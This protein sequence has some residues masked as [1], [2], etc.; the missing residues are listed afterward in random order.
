[1][2]VAIWGA[3]ECGKKVLD[4]LKRQKETEIVAVADKAAAKQEKDWEGYKVCAPEC[5]IEMVENKEIDS[6]VFAF[7][8][9]YFKE[10]TALFKDCVDVNAYIVPSHVQRFMDRFESMEDC[11]VKIDLSKPRLRQFDV[12]LVDH[13]NMKCKGCLRFS[14]LVTEPFF[15]DFDRMIRDWE[16]IKELFWGVERIKL[17]GG[18]PLLSPDIIRYVEEARRIFPDA[19]IMIT[20]NAIL[21]NERQT[22]LFDAMKKNNCFFDISLYAAMEKKEQTIRDIL[23]QY[24]VWYQINYTKG[25]FYKVMSAEGKYDM[26][27][28]YAD[29]TAKNCHHLREGKLS[30]CSRP[31]YVHIMND[32]YG[33]RIPTWDGVWDIYDLHMDAWELDEKLSS[34][35]EACKYCAP[36]ESYQ[37]AR[38]DCINAEMSDWF[39]G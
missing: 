17:M 34:P 7:L 20:T 3:A 13:C 9:R 26:E 37:W 5:L 29:C 35:F 25:D 4:L 11:L 19:D 38:A 2:R 23:D 16:R 6:I 1:M 21:I 18:E 30:V 10:A 33:T 24:G 27:Q 28:A 12:N 22:K 39:V 32:R 36:P 31:Q 8:N 14:N 15:A